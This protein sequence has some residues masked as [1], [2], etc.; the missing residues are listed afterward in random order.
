MEHRPITL[1]EQ[2]CGKP[3]S[4]S[5]D[6]TSKFRRRMLLHCGPEGHHTATLQDS[7]KLGSLPRP[8]KRLFAFRR[9]AMLLLLFPKFL[10]GLAVL[11][12]CL[13]YTSDAATIYSV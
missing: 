3:Q 7:V 9:D 10:R 4:Q 5:Q 13:L 8:D 12:G 6:A 2:A 1:E 11:D